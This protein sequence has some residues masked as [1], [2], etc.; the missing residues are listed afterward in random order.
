MRSVADA[1]LAAAL[2]CHP[3]GVTRPESDHCDAAGAR[4]SPRRSRQ[5]GQREVRH[6]C[7]VDV[8][9]GQH[10]LRRC[11]GAFHV[12]GVVQPPRRRKRFPHSR[13]RAAEL[14]HHR[15]V[16][17]GQPTLEF[18]DRQGAGQDRQDFVALDEGSGD[19]RRRSAHR[20]HTGNDH[21]V[22]TLRE[23]RVH[24]H[25]GA[26]EQRIALGEQCDVATRVE[27]CGNTIGRLDGRSPRSRRHSRRDGRWS[28]WSPGRPDA[29]RSGPHADTA[30]R[31]R[32]R[33]SYRAGRC[34][35]R[36]H[37]PRR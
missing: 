28:R 2:R 26:V 24:V 37:R 12:E 20:R 3:V 34:G 32:A 35:T 23:P 21:G 31:C 11:A 7:L 8:A 6:R 13:I 25:V 1:E 4:L 10:P 14:E 36:R 29:P 17:V 5:H 33:C 22:E 16:A 30:R 18:V 15:G 9:R 27:M 19:R